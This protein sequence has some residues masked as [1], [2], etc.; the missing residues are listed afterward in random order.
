MQDDLQ[1]PIASAEAARATPAHEGQRGSMPDPRAACWGPLF[2]P[3][4]TPPLLPADEE[5]E[6]TAPTPL[7]EPVAARPARP[8]KPRRTRL[9]VLD[10]QAPQELALSDRVFAQVV[11]SWHALKACAMAA[12]GVQGTPTVRMEMDIDTTGRVKAARVLDVEGVTEQQLASCLKTQAHGLR[13]PPDS[14]RRETTR[15]A[16]FVF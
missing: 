7:D 8:G 4:C 16:T 13:F 2:P 9:P 11:G 6:E 5:E 10:D 12:G 15:D 1:A 3:S 14:V